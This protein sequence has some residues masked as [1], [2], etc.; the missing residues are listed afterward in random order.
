MQNPT[1]FF[2]SA[3]RKNWILSSSY[4]PGL[5]KLTIIS[6]AELERV[7]LQIQ[8]EAAAGLHQVQVELEQQRLRLAGPE[9]QWRAS[10]S[11]LW[12]HLGKVLLSGEWQA[13]ER[14]CVAGWVAG[15][16]RAGGGGHQGEG[17][18]D[19]GRVSGRAAGAADDL[20]SQNCW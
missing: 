12:L 17:G 3:I 14:A 8:R 9:E 19:L 6:R 7:E 11:V 5:K 13:L 4:V 1:G 20:L 18:T 15:S 2:V 10:R 16:G